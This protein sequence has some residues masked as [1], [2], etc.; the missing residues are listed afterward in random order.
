[1]TDR[2]AEMTPTMQTIKGKITKLA[3][4]VDELGEIPCA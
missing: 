3:S 4:L 1:M 2:D